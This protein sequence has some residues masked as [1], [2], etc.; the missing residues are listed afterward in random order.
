MDFPGNNTGVGGHFLLQGIFLTHGS[1]PSLPLGMWI[2][3]HW[4]PWEAHSHCTRQQKTSPTSYENR[5]SKQVSLWNLNCRLINETVGLC[6]SDVNRK[7]WLIKR[8]VGKFVRTLY[9]MCYFN[10][11]WPILVLFGVKGITYKAPRTWRGI[12]CILH[13]VGEMDIDHS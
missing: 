1:N 10:K 8:Q 2:L 12:K 7:W 13:L 4:A 11:H 5:V 6:S 3:A 9:S